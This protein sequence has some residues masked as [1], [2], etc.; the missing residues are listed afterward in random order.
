MNWG[1]VSLIRKSI[2]ANF[3]GS[4]KL[5]YKIK[6]CV[7]IVKKKNSPRLEIRNKTNPHKYHYKYNF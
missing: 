5:I 7:K 1:K 3:I 4:W 2:L 6:H